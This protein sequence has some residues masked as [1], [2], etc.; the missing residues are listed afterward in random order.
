MVG[1][2]RRIDRIVFALNVRMLLLSVTA[3][4]CKKKWSYLYFPWLTLDRITHLLV[5]IKLLKTT[6]KS[7]LWNMW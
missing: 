6:Y 3:T 1:D 4:L 7:R 2:A 5:T